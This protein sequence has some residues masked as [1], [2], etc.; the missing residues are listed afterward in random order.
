MGLQYL[1]YLGEIVI[2]IFFVNYDDDKKPQ[3]RKKKLSI[4]TSHFQKN[5]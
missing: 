5:A 3:L 1:L 4:V 2:S